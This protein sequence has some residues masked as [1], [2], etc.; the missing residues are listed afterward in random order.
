MTESFRKAGIYWASA[1]RTEHSVRQAMMIFLIQWYL[2]GK[3]I[4]PAFLG[5][6]QLIIDSS[7]VLL[8]RI[9]I[10]DGTVLEF[11][12]HDLDLLVMLLTIFPLLNVV[13]AV[14]VGALQLLHG[15]AIDGVDELY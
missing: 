13:D 7:G 9:V 4:D 3:S 14:A 1:T 5:L 6:N 15:C 11:L 12:A 8:P 10:A 2:H